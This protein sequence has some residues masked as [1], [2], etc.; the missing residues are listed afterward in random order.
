MA[1]RRG[2]TLRHEG[3][4]V[5][6]MA[7]IPACYAF[8]GRATPSYI[9][10]TWRVDEPHRNRSLPMLMKLRPISAT[11]L[12]SD[13]TPIPEVQLLLKRS[14]WDQL[15]DPPE[16]FCGLGHAW[17][18]SSE[19]LLAGAFAGS[20]TDPRSPRRLQCL[21]LLRFLH[22]NRKSGSLQSISAGSRR[23]PCGG[24]NSSVPSTLQVV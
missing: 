20:F 16:A 15:P 1:P 24:T 9:A 18:D 12:I 11:T 4:I 7:L 13:T 21:V 5:G 14:N 8:E 2:W 19:E 17:P 6:F 22:R 10:S 23:D 3:K